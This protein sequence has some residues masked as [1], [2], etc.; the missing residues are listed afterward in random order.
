[1]S[2]YKKRSVKAPIPTVAVMKRV[3]E[4]HRSPRGGLSLLNMVIDGATE[5][6]E[7]G[8]WMLNMQCCLFP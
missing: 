8:C 4:R 6:L 5:W 3:W 2:P 7:C 1:M